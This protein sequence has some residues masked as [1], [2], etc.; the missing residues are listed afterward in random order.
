[1]AGAHVDQTEAPLHTRRFQ[2][3]RWLGAG[4]MGVVFEALDVRR[5]TRVALKRVRRLGPEA[6][7]RFKTEFRALQDLR[8][9]NLV[10]L[11]ELICDRDQWFFTMEL[12]DGVD[13][14]AHV[15]A[16]AARAELAVAGTLEDGAT[17][18]EPWGGRAPRDG[19]EAAPPARERRWFDEAR[20]RAA[21]AQ[22]VQGVTAL[23]AAGKVHRDIKPSNILVTREGRVVLLDFGIIADV[24]HGPDSHAAGTPL[25]MAPEQT[26]VCGIAPAADWYAVGLVL[27]EG[28]TGRLPF[29]AS[30]YEA[31]AL[32]K[33]IEPPAPATLAPG[34][35]VDLDRLCMDLLRIDPCERPDGSEVLRRL[36]VRTVEPGP[37]GRFV[38]RARELEDLERC[39]A[40]VEGG[41][42]HTL[43]VHGESGAGKTALV[44]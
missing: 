35:P 26:D 30:P 4:G 40:A 42:A 13:F 21:L 43:L 1:M 17:D 12:L 31:L 34:V 6:L 15:G 36:S 25:Y 14:L 28:L 3:V 2:I 20:L 8:H 38:G 23:H 16:P 41:A 32:K 39:F 33:R 44:A 27:Y 9:P 18:P 37:R 22:L 29:G 24:R 7:L 5:G 19:A 10:R 11:D